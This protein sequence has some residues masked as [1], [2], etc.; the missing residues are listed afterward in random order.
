[1]ATDAIVQKIANANKTEN[2]TVKNVL[3][4]TTVNVKTA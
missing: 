3:V 4:K 1:M 2:V